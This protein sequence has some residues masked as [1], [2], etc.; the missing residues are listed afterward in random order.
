MEEQK[1]PRDAK[2]EILDPYLNRADQKSG[3]TSED[4]AALKSERV[5]AY[6]GMDYVEEGAHDIITY[7]EVNAAQQAW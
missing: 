2:R 6:F 1:L 3:E 4:K 7:D 5:D